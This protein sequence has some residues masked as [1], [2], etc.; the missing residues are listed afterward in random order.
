M[1]ANNRLEVKLREQLDFLKR[2]CDLFDQGYESEA[3]RIATALRVLFHHTKY[4]AALLHQL[5]FAKKK[6]MLSSAHGHGDWQDYLKQQI[7]I[8]SK[9]PVKMTPMLGSD[10]RELAMS[11]W[12]EETLFIH[13][14]KK[15]SRRLVILSAANKDG[16][17]HVDPK[18]EAYYEVLAEGE[19]AVSISVTGNW[20]FDENERVRFSG[21]P[22]LEEGV[23]YYAK[24]AHLALI[25]QFAHE[26]L[27][28]AQHFNWV[29]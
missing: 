15:Y 23:K 11:D 17:A 10:F 29:S 21:E 25:R 16:G 19:Y 12:W 26:V 28:T 2:S 20:G 18:L 22:W 5:G 13:D 14:K 24:N 4:S 9:E 8:G 3:I 6:K 27:T 7:A 1:K